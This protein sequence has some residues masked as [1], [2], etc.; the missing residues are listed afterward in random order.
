MGSAYWGAL[1]PR[2]QEMET[3]LRRRIPLGA[4]TELLNVRPRIYQGDKD[5][6]RRQVLI[7]SSPK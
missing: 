5:I 7:P 4:A 2:F 6:Y 1:G 3:S